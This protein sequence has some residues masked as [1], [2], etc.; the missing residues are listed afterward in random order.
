MKSIQSDKINLILAFSAVLF[1]IAM[2]FPT[3]RAGK[4]KFIE[5]AL[6]NPKY[7]D[8]V[9]AIQISDNL[10]TAE[11]KK[12]GDKWTVKSQN[13][14]MTT[15]ADEKTVQSLIENFI[16]IS[17]AYHVS[18]KI[19]RENKT[20]TVTF[21][22][23]DGSMCSKVD[24]FSQNQLT[25]RISLSADSKS[26]W[27]ISDSVSQFLTSDMSFWSK[28]EIFPFSEN[29]VQATL[30]D[31][32]T[33]RTEMTTQKKE[34]DFLI[35]LRHGTILPDLPQPAMLD[36][37]LS[38]QNAEGR[39]TTISV[40]KNTSNGEESYFYTMLVKKSEIDD[41]T[42][43]LFFQSENASYEISGWTYKN[44]TSCFRQQ[45]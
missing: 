29:P 22:K 35:S 9:G 25:S 38:V 40:Y 12:I 33:S 42:Q 32:E 44:I 28:K 20:A 31:A 10:D 26:T 39:I 45:S 21:T 3:N 6:L 4:Q 5:T 7:R 17:K 1:T 13:G 23:K 34:L 15:F 16:K 14:G 19:S 18:E 37:K 24:F 27:E 41:G 30:F 11:L 2:L 43:N 8:E 36:S